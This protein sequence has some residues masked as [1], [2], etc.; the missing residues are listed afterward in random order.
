M[1]NNREGELQTDRRICVEK[2]WF[3]LKSLG[4]SQAGNILWN[5]LDIE[6]NRSDNLRQF[7]SKYKFVILQKYESNTRISM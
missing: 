6:L 5:G 7:K 2:M 1:L 4:L 3:T